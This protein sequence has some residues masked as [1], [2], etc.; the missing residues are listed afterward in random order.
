[1]VLPT[2]AISGWRWGSSRQTAQGRSSSQRQQILQIAE[3]L[4]FL[5][6]MGQQPQKAAAACVAAPLIQP[7]AVQEIVTNF[8]QRREDKDT[9]GSATAAEEQKAHVALRTGD[10]ELSHIDGSLLPGLF[11]E[12]STFCAGLQQDSQPARTKRKG[13]RLVR[14]PLYSDHRTQTDRQAAAFRSQLPC[15]SASALI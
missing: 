12:L 15:R 5:P 8:P 9:L 3:H 11:Q 4:H 10:T 13:F 7:I 6:Q 14:A 2:W 1:M